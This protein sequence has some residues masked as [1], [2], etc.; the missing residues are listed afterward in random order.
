[1]FDISVVW[2]F[3]FLLNFRKLCLGL[4][5]CSL[6]VFL[7]GCVK[8]VYSCGVADFGSD[9][10]MLAWLSVLSLLLFSVLTWG[11]VFF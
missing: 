4:G 10:V 6:C 3:C 11:Q 5:N 2:K 8:Q 1:M 9:F 7:F